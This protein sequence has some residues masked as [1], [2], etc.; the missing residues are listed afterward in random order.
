M[1]KKVGK[2]N[3]FSCDKAING[4]ILRDDQMLKASHRDF[5]ITM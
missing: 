5:K 1:T 4:S 2:W 3:H